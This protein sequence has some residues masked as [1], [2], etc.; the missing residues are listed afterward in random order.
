MDG[1]RKMN[2]KELLKALRTSELLGFDL[3]HTSTG[4]TNVFEVISSYAPHQ[5]TLELA[6]LEQQAKMKPYRFIMDGPEFNIIGYI[7]Q[8]ETIKEFLVTEE[9]FKTLIKYL[10]KEDSN[11]NKPNGLPD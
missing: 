4:W 3:V 9:I 7:K 11:D 8:N 2:R 5:E 6:W 1:G 10:E